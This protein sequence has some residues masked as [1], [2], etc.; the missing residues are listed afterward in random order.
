MWLEYLCQSV[1][2]LVATYYGVSNCNVKLYLFR[3]SYLK[4]THSTV[5]DIQFKV[6]KKAQSFS[7]TQLQL[8]NYTLILNFCAVCIA[9]QIVSCY[10]H[11]NQFQLAITPNP[12]LPPGGP[13][14]GEDFVVGFFQQDC[15]EY[16]A[17]MF[18]KLS[19]SH[20]P[21]QAYRA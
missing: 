12:P 8:A 17:N 5:N 2:S 9:M 19:A 6:S 4:K 7:A 20:R 15:L 18:K 14:G 13:V 11:K 10:F 16:L 1:S 21:S 3:R